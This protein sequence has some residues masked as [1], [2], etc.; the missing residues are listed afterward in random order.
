MSYSASTLAQEAVFNTELNA[1]TGND[2]GIWMSGDG[3]AADANGNLYLAT[4]NGDYDGSTDFG[5][6]ILKLT[7]PAN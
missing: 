6:T 1:I 7:G 5:N 2:G 4:G 3:V